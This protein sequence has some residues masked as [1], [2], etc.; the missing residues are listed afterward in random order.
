MAVSFCAICHFLIFFN[1]SLCFLLFPP[2]LDLT[3]WLKSHMVVCA[4]TAPCLHT[5]FLWASMLCAVRAEI[6]QLVFCWASDEIQ[7][8]GFGGWSC[9]LAFITFITSCHFSLKVAS[10]RKLMQSFR[11]TTSCVTAHCFYGKPFYRPL[12]DDRGTSVHTGLSAAQPSP[13]QGEHQC[14]TN[15]K[16]LGR[17]CDSLWEAE[18]FKHATAVH[19]RWREII[20]D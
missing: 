6:L 3:V 8:Q 13:S 12:S 19:V 11:F 7:L 16:T 1:F 20:L 18:F 2:R 9:H 17:L 10:W 15:H 14:S 5:Y 4:G